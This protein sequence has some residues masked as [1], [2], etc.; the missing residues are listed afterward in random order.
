MDRRVQKTRQALQDALIALI[1]ERGYEA[2]T[3]QDVLDRANV[4]RSTFYA[5]FYDL[6][7]LL[8]SEF[9]V[10]QTEFEQAMSQNS[11]SESSVWDISRIMFQ[12]AQAYQRLYKAVT[13]KSSGQIIQSH[14]HRYLGS[15]FREA[16]KRDWA[17]TKNELVSLELLEH[18]LVSSFMALLTWWLDKNLPLSAEAMAGIYQ[19]LCKDGIEKWKIQKEA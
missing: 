12:H 5:H 13:G 16:L 10:L 3:V 11:P 8:Q 18:Y 9:E 2:I 17:G 15:Q 19:D 7:D 4:G 6:E 1:L 14:L